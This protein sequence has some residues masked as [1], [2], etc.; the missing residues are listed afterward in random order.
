MSYERFG[1]FKVFLFHR[2]GTES[3]GW[4]LLVLMKIF[5]S[6]IAKTRISG[7]KLDDFPIELNHTLALANSVYLMIPRS[8]AE[9]WVLYICRSLALNWL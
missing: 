4:D 6:L 9:L 1:Y 2:G 5:S 8:I 7:A 3:R